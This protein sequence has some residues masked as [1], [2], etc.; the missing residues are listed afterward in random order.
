MVGIFTPTLSAIF[1]SPSQKSAS[2]NIPLWLP[3]ALKG[4]IAPGNLFQFVFLW[5][6]IQTALI[7][8]FLF[9]KPLGILEKYP[10]SH[11]NTVFISWA[12]Y[13]L[14]IELKSEY[15]EV[16]FSALLSF[17]EYHIHPDTQVNSVIS[18]EMNDFL[19]VIRNVKS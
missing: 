2:P 18:A 1:S 15:L 14:N 13:R 4:R 7:Q 10:S 8:I 6:Y 11:F 9:L 12:I 16:L 3:A 19:S 17:L 5:L